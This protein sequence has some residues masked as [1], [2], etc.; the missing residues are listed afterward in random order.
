MASF[1]LP[2]P[3][4]AIM[5]VHWGPA[6]HGP[7][8]G[9]ARRLSLAKK[10]CSVGL[11]LLTHLFRQNGAVLLQRENVVYLHDRICSAFVC[12]VDVTNWD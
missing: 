4:V 2:H 11:T 1:Y 6:L 5:L 9:F 8:S 3:E 7:V 12:Q 10:Q